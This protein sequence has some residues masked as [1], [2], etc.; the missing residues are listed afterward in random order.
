MEDLINK[1]KNSDLK[2][3]SAAT[4]IPYDRMYKWKK[5][6]SKPKLEDFE[7]LV[8]Y[9]NGNFSKEIVKPS[10]ELVVANPNKLKK[11]A[12]VPF[13]NA[14]FMAGNAEQF[15]DDATIYPEYY[16]DVP[17]FAGCTAFRA[18]SD[19]MENRIRSGS[20]LFGIKIEDW[21]S[22]LEYGQIY[23][24]TCTDHRR[25]LKYIRRA[26]EGD[27]RHY[28]LLKSENENYDDFEMPKDKIKNI[29]LIEGWLDKRT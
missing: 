9:F 3:I 5:G 15:Y 26:V 27:P 19:S 20:I 16:M 12:L 28:F 29:W 23:G 13:Y 22:H 6:K 11:N 4:K 14:D 17:E 21:K 10:G 2:S 8:N 25:Y 1:L 24:I 18:Y 7:T